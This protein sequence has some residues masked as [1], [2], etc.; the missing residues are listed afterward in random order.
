M[1]TAEDDY[2]GNS[3]RLQGRQRQPTTI[4]R[5]ETTAQVDSGGVGEVLEKE[6]LQVR[7]GLRFEVTGTFKQLDDT[8]A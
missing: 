1:T 5:V 2:D 3:T 4:R 6:N 7:V 8:V